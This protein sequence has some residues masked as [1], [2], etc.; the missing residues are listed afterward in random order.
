L[1]HSCI[2]RGYWRP[3][4]WFRG[5][6]DEKRARGGQEIIWIFGVRLQPGIMRTITIANQKG[7]CGKTTTAVN[8]GATPAEEGERT[9]AID[10]DL[11]EYAA[12]AG[13][14]ISCGKP[15]REPE[16]ES[17]LPEEMINARA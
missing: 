8:L 17:V 12:P 5:R 10:L 7:G 15:R 14:M 4:G 3:P 1:Q 9:P 16:V 13:D 6:T 2:K 11:Q